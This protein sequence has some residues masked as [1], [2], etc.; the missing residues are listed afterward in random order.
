MTRIFEN[1]DTFEISSKHETVEFSVYDQ[2]VH[3]DCSEEAGWE[4][5]RTNFVLTREEATALKIFLEKQGF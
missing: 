1:K 4:S 3:I 5:Q 2:N